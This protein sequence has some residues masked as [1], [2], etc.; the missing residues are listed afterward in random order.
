M[1]NFSLI[2]TITP[3]ILINICVLGGKLMLNITALSLRVNS[4]LLPHL[5]QSHPN[6][7]VLYDSLS[8]I[9][10]CLRTVKTGMN[11]QRRRTSRETFYQCIWLH[12]ETS[13]RSCISDSRDDAQSCK[14]VLWDGCSKQNQMGEN[15]SQKS[16][17][18]MK[19]WN[20]VGVS[21]TN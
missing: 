15:N 16:I 9:W 1:S 2:T 3:H 14:Q 6:L 4:L 7:D 10:T 12:G 17:F 20:I 8:N 21:S 18:S 5:H 19:N 11:T 13:S